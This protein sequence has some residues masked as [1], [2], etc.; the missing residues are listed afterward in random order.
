[1]DNNNKKEE[2]EKKWKAVVVKAVTD[3]DFKGQLVADPVAVM[4]EN[5][6]TLPEGCKAAVGTGGRIVIQHPSD[7]SDELK[8]EVK[9]WMLRLDITSEFGRDDGKKIDNFIMDGD[10]GAQ[11]S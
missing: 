10:E 2:L 3:D 1:M 9:W 7:A 11:E 4:N 8:A 6:I 5:G